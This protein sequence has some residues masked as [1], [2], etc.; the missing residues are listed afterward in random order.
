MA[1]HI[2]KRPRLSN[3]DPMHLVLILSESIYRTVDYR[4]RVE[5]RGLLHYNMSEHDGE[6]KVKKGEM[7]KRSTSQ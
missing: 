2:S 7:S 4:L 3:R 1:S 6:G 5:C